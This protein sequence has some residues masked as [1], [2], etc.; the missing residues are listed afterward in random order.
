MDQ[1]QFN[2]HDQPWGRA[3]GLIVGCIVILTGIFRTVGPAEIVLR[4]ITAGVLTALT[5]RAFIWLMVVC[6]VDSAGH[7][8]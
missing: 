6:T 1:Q 4:S 3:F 7:K 5:V 8:G 2:M